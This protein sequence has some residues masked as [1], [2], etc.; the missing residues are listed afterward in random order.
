MVSWDRRDP[1]V[2]QKSKE[3]RNKILARVKLEILAEIIYKSLIPPFGKHTII[4]TN[5]P[6]V[7]IKLL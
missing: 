1:I 5:E 7:G 4:V 2:L 6:K 3:T